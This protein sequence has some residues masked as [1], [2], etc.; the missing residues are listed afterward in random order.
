V[1][2]IINTS[3]IFQSPNHHDAAYNKGLSF[4]KHSGIQIKENGHLWLGEGIFSQFAEIYHRGQEWHVIA[5]HQLSNALGIAPLSG[6][7]YKYKQHFSEHPQ[8][9]PIRHHSHFRSRRRVLSAGL[10]QSQTSKKGVMLRDPRL[11]L[12]KDQLQRFGLN[13][14]TVYTQERNISDIIATVQYAVAAQ[15]E[16][17]LPPGVK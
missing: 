11:L 8:K 6:Y 13:T 9:L 4:Y 17:G 10:N 2:T 15:G 7:D 12:Q 14:Q 5:M 16:Q 1:V 3:N